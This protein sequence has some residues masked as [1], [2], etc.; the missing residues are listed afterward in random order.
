MGNILMPNPKSAL[1]RGILTI[2]IGSV[3]LFVPG[4]TMQT[5][6]ITIGSMLLVNGLITMIISNRK[7]SRTMNHFWS[8][9]GLISI[10]FGL[11]FIASPSVIVKIF[12]VFIGIVLLLMGLFQFTRAM[13]ALSWS[14]WSWIYFLIA[15]ITL[16]SGIFM[17]TNPFKSAEAILSFL[18]A[19]LI[20]NGISELFM[21][22]KIGRK[23]PTYKGSDVQDIT[24]EEM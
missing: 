20:L 10:I 5:V 16:A 6:M 13:G 14:F 8:A 11:A 4:L 12:V 19:L 9:Q 2:S 15:I 17:L 23:S 7:K 22:W 18:G 3:F 21:A 24:Y 1:I